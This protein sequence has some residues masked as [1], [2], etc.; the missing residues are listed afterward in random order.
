MHAGG[1]DLAQPR[2]IDYCF[3]FPD[4]Q[5]ALAFARVV[6]EENS[7]VCISLCKNRKVWQVIVQ[8][9]MVPEHAHITAIEA[10]LGGKAGA[11]G[12]KAD[13]WGCMRVNRKIS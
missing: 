12:G 13:G 9:F 6:D 4:R 8:R 11:E 7:I 3:I 1:D 10:E 2:M 5:Q